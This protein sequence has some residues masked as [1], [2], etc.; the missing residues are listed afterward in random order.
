M[1]HITIK[2]PHPKGRL[3]FKMDLHSDLAAGVYLRP[4]HL[5]GFC[6]GGSKAILCTGDQHYVPYTLLL[7]S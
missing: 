3:F 4:P 2:K 1:D 6:S 5:R 7:T